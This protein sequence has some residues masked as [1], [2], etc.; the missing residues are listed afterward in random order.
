MIEAEDAVNYD[1][2]GALR[3]VLG[4]EFADLIRDF[5]EQMATGLARMEFALAQQDSARIR[6]IAHTLKGSALSLHCKP[7]ADCCARVERGADQLAVGNEGSLL[8]DLRDSVRATV[9]AID[10]WIG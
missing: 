4:L 8:E 5:N 1:A 9:R 2:L 3:S 7:L 6:S 10:D